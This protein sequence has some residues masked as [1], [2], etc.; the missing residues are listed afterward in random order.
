MA[1]QL[2]HPE[3]R[4]AL[5]EL[6]ERSPG[7]IVLAGVVGAQ[8]HIASAVGLDRQGPA[9]RAIEIVA[10]RGATVPTC[11]GRVPVVTVDALGFEATIEAG[12][13]AVDVAGAAYS[14]PAPEHILGM[15]LAASDLD[16]ATKWTCFALM[17]VFEGRLDLEE[18]RGFV[19][20]SGDPER[21]S[22]LHEL[23][24]LAA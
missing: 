5:V 7:A 24:Y 18:V 3:L 19:K 13:R 23:A 2:R 16:T 8:I 9:A 12:R 20:R 4:A 10:L 14:V 21:E 17:R 15:M 11:V 1:W 6:L 22:L